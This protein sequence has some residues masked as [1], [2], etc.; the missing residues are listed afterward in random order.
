MPLSLCSCS[1]TILRLPHLSLSLSL[2]LFR[3]HTYAQAAPIPRFIGK[4]RFSGVFAHG[5]GMKS[6]EK[7]RKK[8]CSGWNPELRM[9]RGS[10]GA[11]APCRRAPVFPRSI[12][13]STL[14][15]RPLS[16][17]SFPPLPL[18]PSVPRFLML[19]ATNCPDGRCVCS[20][21]FC[22]SCMFICVCVCVCVCA[23]A[24]VCI[25]VCMCVCVAFVSVCVR[26]CVCVCARAPSFV[27]VY[28]YIYFCLC[29]AS[30]LFLRVYVCVCLSLYACM[31]IHVY[32]HV[33]RLWTSDVAQP[34]QQS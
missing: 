19:P 18:P 4:S 11:K 13:S 2:S 27:C 29:L 5:S 28:K 33:N 9:A 24:C 31:Y 21:F 14:L 6:P 17:H 20:Y 12:T 15:H 8:L 32:I 10:Y 3:V 7:H 30:V 34:P 1:A 23:C 25:C 16:P 22:V 26:A